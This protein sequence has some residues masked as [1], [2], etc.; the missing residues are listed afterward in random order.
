MFPGLFSVILFLVSGTF[1]VVGNALLKAGM[2]EV[3][4][5]NLI[6]LAFNFKVVVGFLLY[7]ASSVLY[8]KLLTMTDVTKVYP[9]LVAYMAVAILFLGAIFLHESLTLTKIFGVML[10]IAGI[11]FISR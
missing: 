10:V 5:L 7:G 3:G 9:A 6:R 4:G 8:L 11:F 2:N 1:A